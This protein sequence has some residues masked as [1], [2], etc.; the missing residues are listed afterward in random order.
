[1]NLNVS[2][3]QT[4]A[5]LADI[6][7]EG[8]IEAVCAARAA[9][10]GELESSLSAMAHDKTEFYP[11]GFQQRQLELIVNTG[12]RV[13]PNGLRGTASGTA[14]RRCAEAART[15]KAPVNA[16]GLYRIGEDGKLVLNTTSEQF[17][18]PLGHGF[19][20]YQLIERARR[21]GV[22]SATHNNTRGH[23]TRLVEEEIVRIANGV[24]PG[25][26][27]QLNWVIGA[28]DL[29]I[30]NRVLN[31]ETGSLAMEAALKLI[32]A[33][34]YRCE[35]QIEMPKFHGK[36]P[37]L[38]VVGDEDAGMGG[39]CHGTSFISQMLRGLWPEF[40]QKLEN[41]SVCIV[42][43]V[44][45][46]DQEDLR[47]AF[48]GL[49]AQ[50]Q[51]AGFI[52]EMI[53]MN[54]GA[55]V[56]TR[57]FLQEAYALC[58]Q[59]DIPTVVDETQTGLWTPGLFMFREHSLKPSVVVVGNGS[60]AGEH[61]TS[62]VLFSS[63]IDTL[64]QFGAMTTTAQDELG[65]LAFLITMGWALENAQAVAEI[66]EYYEQ[67]VRASA[68]AF[69][70]SVVTVEGRR[71]LLGFVFAHAEVARLFSYTLGEMGLDNSLQTWGDS[72][73][74]VVTKLPLTADCDIVRFVYGR[75]RQALAKACA[76]SVAPGR[77]PAAGGAG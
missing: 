24:A 70:A 74:A 32:L 15:S 25:N 61:S 62:R 67:Q 1:M 65:S 47:A 77:P 69:P 35:P 8:Y 20:G 44:K 29:R 48:R 63:V 19:P 26:R 5:S 71:H 43:A 17:H 12:A 64:P 58:E 76:A 11:A 13:L 57:D 21:L 23:I 39:N 59:N 46:N 10:T 66:G 4:R 56:L 33:R 3:A 16:L 22:P 42:R 7:G 9:L 31:L 34:F 60:P 37:V 30:V 40:R 53:L 28:K 41:T 68:Q 72:K 75:L 38:L 18:T 2:F 54:H 73:A 27:A 50:R 51:I 36:V 55:R 52:H 6:L 45:P 49:P 14:S